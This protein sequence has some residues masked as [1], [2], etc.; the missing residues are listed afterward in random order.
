MSATKF[1]IHNLATNLILFPIGFISSI[2]IT[3]LL[4]AEGRG[5]YTY[6]ILMCN[7]FVP[8]LS[9]GYSGGVSYYVANRVYKIKDI[10]YTNVI[11]SFCIGLFTAS[12]IY[13]TYLLGGLG[14]T[15]EALPPYLLLSLFVVIPV[16][17]CVLY[18][19]KSLHA[20]NKFEKT[21][22]LIITRRILAPTLIIVLALL[23]FDNRVVAACLGFVLALF[24][25]AVDVF[26]YIRKTYSPVL[27]FNKKFVKD[28]FQYGVKGWFGDLAVTANVRIDQI[29]LGAVASAGS[30]GYYSIAVMLS[31]LF[32][33]PVK[34]VGAVLYNQIASASKN[35]NFD[36]ALNTFAMMHRILFVATFMVLICFVPFSFVFIPFLYG[37]E[38]INSVLPFL[39]LLPGTLA[40]ITTKF[41]TK[42]FTASGNI[43]ITNLV[44]IYSSIISIL[45]YATLIPLLGIKGAAIAASTGYTIGA[46]FSI[47]YFTKTYSEPIS[48]LFL[49]KKQ[50]LIW[51]KNKFVQ[52]YQSVTKK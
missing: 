23:V 22:Y 40:M 16:S 28:S 8:L 3:R 15:A 6:Y 7:F 4:G 48:R 14:K 11:T 45:L 32:W 27:T 52:F 24:Y 46:I 18:T 21:N 19:L 33:I 9:M 31:E 51:L 39:L 25:V 10:F 17:A 13:L 38:F 50:D 26:F 47:Y 35:G 5:F 1:S 12:V 29:I 34:S 43:N 30:L 2:I 44:Q 42:L 20:D 37:Q 49:L 41:L 36:T